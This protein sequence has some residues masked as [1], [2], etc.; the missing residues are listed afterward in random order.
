MGGTCGGSISGGNYTTAPINSNCTVQAN[1]RETTTSVGGY[2]EDAPADVANVISC[3]SGQNFDSW[4]AKTAYYS[5]VAIP[6]GKILSFPFTTADSTTDNGKVDVNTLEGD[7]G[8][9][10]MFWRSW[11]SVA[12][13]G[14]R[15]NN[16][17]K[18]EKFASTAILN[19]NYTQ[20]PSG[21]GCNLG[22]TGQ[23]LHLNFEVRCFPEYSDC[24]PGTRYNQ[25]YWMELKNDAR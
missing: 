12:P 24:T 21:S 15:L 25:S 1:F 14:A 20:A 17:S 6:A 2:C 10:Q 8:A 7:L 11:F 22:T 3:S 9:T 13:G 5:Q 19:F 4:P 18:C 23:V 16:S